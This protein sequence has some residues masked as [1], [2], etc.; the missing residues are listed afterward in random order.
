MNYEKLIAKLDKYTKEHVKE[1]RY[2]H[3]LRV[4]DTCVF[5]CNKFGLDE[6]KGKLMGVA[7][8]MCKSC[9]QEKMLELASKDGNPILEMEKEK[10]SLLHGRAAAVL[11]K[12]KFQYDDSEVLEAI[13]NHTSGKLDMCDYTK[14][15]ILADRLEPGRTHI[16]DEKRQELFKMSLNE[17]IYTVL[18]ENFDYIKSKGYTVYPNTEKMIQQLQDLGF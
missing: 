15:L 8:D 17:M 10:F 1:E 13:A 7:H 12:E 9:S 2:K 4:A 3:C 14:V 11:L 16:T 18:K 5:L 6:N